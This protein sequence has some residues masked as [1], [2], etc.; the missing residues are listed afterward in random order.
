MRTLIALAMLCAPMR[1]KLL[2]LP[3]A[4]LLSVAFCLIYFANVPRIS[5]LEFQSQAQREIPP[6]THIEQV[7]EW[8]ESKGYREGAVPVPDCTDTTKCTIYGQ[9]YNYR[10]NWI[11]PVMLCYEFQ[12][13]SFGRRTDFLS[14][15]E[16]TIGP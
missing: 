6:G 8:L 2:L 16:M 1:R 10:I 13:D 4:L 3:L 12:F 7:V 5:V 11:F 14:V 9:F 15:R